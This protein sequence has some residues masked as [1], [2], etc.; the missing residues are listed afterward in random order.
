MVTP[1][2][3]PYDQGG[4]GTARSGWSAADKIG[5]GVTGFSALASLLGRHGDS[6]IKRLGL[7]GQRSLAKR[8]QQRQALIEAL[9]RQSRT[10]EAQASMGGFGA[11]HDPLL[12]GRMQALGQTR[13]VA[14]RATGI[15]A[16]QEAEESDLRNMIASLKLQ[17]R[18]S[19]FADIGSIAGMFT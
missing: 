10:R 1:Y 16:R 7:E 2:S 18:Q 13:D 12:M 4:S 8:L 5:V 9:S 15:M 3:S 19:Q 6:D 17:R 11:A 14:P